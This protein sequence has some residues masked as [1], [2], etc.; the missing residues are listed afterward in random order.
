V[1]DKRGLHAASDD[2]HMAAVT[3]TYWENRNTYENFLEL[4]EC[5]ALVTAQ[6]QACVDATVRNLWTR[7]RGKGVPVPSG[8]EVLRVRRNENLKLW[9][10][11]ALKRSL[12]KEGIAAGGTSLV[13]YAPRTKS[14]CGFLEDSP[15]DIECNEW[16]LWHGTTPDGAERICEVDFKQRLAGSSTGMLY[17]PGTYFTD[18]CT[19]A[20]EYCR[21]AQGGLYSMLLCRVVGGRVR[22][23]DEVNPDAGLAGLT[24]DVLHGSFD[25][26]LGDREKCRGT[27][28]EYV[29]YASDQ[30]YPE[31]IV[32]Y[33]RKYEVS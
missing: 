11:Y 25:S 4:V 14:V 3:P 29:I 5:D 12:I 2:L 24:G 1:L 32:M 33:R 19:K 30:A 28:K 22:Y 6:V 15:L 7:D 21:E 18:S 20:D 8:Y 10:K 9:R 17:G 16:V 26:V 13:H 31:F 23:T 27:F